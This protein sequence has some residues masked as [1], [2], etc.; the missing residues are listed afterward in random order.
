MRTFYPPPDPSVVFWRKEKSD[1]TFDYATIQSMQK[2]G[3]GNWKALFLVPGQAPFYINQN[4]GELRNWEPILALTE[5]NL[6]SMVER[7]AQRVTAILQE[8]GVDSSEIIPAAMEVVQKDTVADAIETAVE[9]TSDYEKEEAE[10]T[11]AVDPDYW[12]SKD[13]KRNK[14]TYA[15]GVCDKKYAY[16]KSLKKHLSKA[17]NVLEE[18]LSKNAK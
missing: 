5:E 18:K 8:Q 16:E 13:F 6:E 9:A 17:H 3:N 4:N 10:V 7:I 15:C 12:L 2:T 11:D 14:K 1:G